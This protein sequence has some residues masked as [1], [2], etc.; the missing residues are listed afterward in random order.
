MTTESD[1]AGL[2]SGST[3]CRHDDPVRASTSPIAAS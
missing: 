2:A 3:R 1:A